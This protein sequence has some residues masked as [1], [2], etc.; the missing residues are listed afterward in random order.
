MRIARLSVFLLIGLFFLSSCSSSHTDTLDVGRN[1]ASS[2]GDG[3]RV[4]YSLAD[5]TDDE[6]LSDDIR[7]AVFGDDDNAPRNF[8][9]ILSARADSVVEI[10]IFLASSRSMALELSEFCLMRIHKIEKLTGAV[11]EVMI[12]GDLVI[13][14]VTDTE[15]DL[16]RIIR[17]SV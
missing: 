9:L 12:E 16:E 11:G 5:E 13:Y 4:Y 17:S 8:T 7:L 6:F 15:D 10:G 2:L 14:Y 3:V 1:I